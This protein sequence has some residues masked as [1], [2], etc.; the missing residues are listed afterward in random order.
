MNHVPIVK[1]NI[2]FR[3]IEEMKKYTTDK[4]RQVISRGHEGIVIRKSSSFRDFSTSTVKYVR[5]G[6]VQTD[7]H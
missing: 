5:R 7:K 3:T 1:E 4:A 6:H 2:K